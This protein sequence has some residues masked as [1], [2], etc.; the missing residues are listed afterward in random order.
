[1]SV[2]DVPRARWT[3]MLEQ[4][5][6]AHRGWRASVATVR[7]GPE[8]A[9]RTDWHPL[10]SVT[11]ARTGTRVTA[12]FANFQGAPAIC[13]K[14]PR[15]LAVDTRED[16][17]ERALEIDAAEGT[18]VRL[19]FRAT[20]LPEEVDGMAPAE[21]IE[22]RAPVAIAGGTAATLTGHGEITGRRR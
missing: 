6:R 8:L 11:V 4:F 9:F 13:V 16:G 20:A 10:E 18:F 14:A 15:A 1:M 17:A 19:V 7:P 21:L 12:I 2:H 3:G 5:S 22:P